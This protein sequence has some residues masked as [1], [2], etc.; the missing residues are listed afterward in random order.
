MLPRSRSSKKEN[1]IIW[2]RTFLNE[3]TLRGI[4]TPNSPLTPS[5]GYGLIY[6]YTVAGKLCYIGR[7]RSSLIERMRRYGYSDKMQR[8]IL[9]AYGNNQLEIA[10]KEVR[11]N[12]LAQKE[13]SEIN[14]HSQSSALWNIQDTWPYAAT[15]NKKIAPLIIITIC[16]SIVFLVLLLFYLVSFSKNPSDSTPTNQQPA[17]TP[18]TETQTKTPLKEYK[19]CAELKKDYPRGISNVEHPELYALNH[20]KDGDG[21][22]WACEPF[23]PN[24]R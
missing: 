10:T 18:S 22:G 15:F 17:T 14:I 8:E 12:L 5:P 2:Q 21:D 11:L 9:K 1:D 7:T 3:K 23:Y 13:K 16:F 6:Y 4:S 19:N 24:N 20:E